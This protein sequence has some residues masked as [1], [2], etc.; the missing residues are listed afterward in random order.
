MVVKRLPS[1]SVPDGGNWLIYRGGGGSNCQFSWDAFVGERLSSTPILLSSPPAKARAAASIITTAVTV[2]ATAT[3]T[4][5]TTATAA[6]TANY[7]IFKYIVLGS[8]VCE[9]WYLEWLHCLAALQLGY[10]IMTLGCSIT[11]PF[12]YSIRKPLSSWRRAHA[13]LRLRFSSLNAWHWST[14]SIWQLLE[15]AKI[16]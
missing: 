15:Q 6:I 11:S 5:T 7:I 16:P 1:Q 4:A 3:T 8:C 2:T 14:H 12:C 10:C 9:Y 13:A